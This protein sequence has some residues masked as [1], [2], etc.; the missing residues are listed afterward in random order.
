[1]KL[2]CI[3]IGCMLNSAFLCSQVIT[4][5]YSM[6]LKPKNG[7][8]Y[9]LADSA[10]IAEVIDLA[11]LPDL[12]KPYHY[13]PS[14]LHE[15]QYNTCKTRS[16][17]Y[18][19]YPNYELRLE[20]DLAISENP[21]PF[22]VYIHGGGW[23]HGTLTS[24][25][26]ISQY[27]AVNGGVAGVRISYSLSKE[28]GSSILN[29]LEDV[30]DAVRFIQAH[31]KELNI[32]PERFGFCGG[33][34][35]G[36]LSAISGMTIPGT[37]LVVCYAGIFDLQ[38]AS[39]ITEAKAERR[40]YFKDLNPEVLRKASAVY[41]IPDKHQPAVLLIHGTG[42]FVVE[43]EQSESFTQALRNAGNKTVELKLYPGYGHD[44]SSKKCDLK[45]RVFFDTYNFISKYIF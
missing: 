5:K 31:A 13:V 22:M 38:K 16:Y 45:E 44:I 12:L 32:D 9:Y 35:G 37:R 28:K 4:N 8:A 24:S 39:A 6:V 11:T 18:K 43:H 23:S 30:Q 21:S 3:L 20:V 25:R 7:G 41:H 2:I 26:D 34:A 15:S 40:K 14:Q 10:K 1:M 19:R 27:T 36:H 17:V 42:D 33:S 29:A